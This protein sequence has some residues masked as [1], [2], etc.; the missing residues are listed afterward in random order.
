M[1]RIPAGSFLMGSPSDEPGRHDDEGPQHKLHLQEFFLARTPITQ[2][3]WR[4]VA[5]WQPLEGESAWERE[6][7]QDPLGSEGD[8]R[9]R[10][11]DRPVANVSWHDA[12]EFCRRLSKRTGKS[13][14]L[15]SEAQW[16]Y[17]CRA[18]RSTPFYFGATISPELANYD[19]SSRYAE[20]PKGENRQQTTEVGHF[21]ANVWGLHDMHG[22]VWE[23]CLDHWHSSYV[24][25]EEQ[26]PTDGSAWIK[27]SAKEDETR[28]LRGGSWSSLPWG[29]RSAYRVFLNPGDA[30][31]SVGFRV[32]CLPQDLLLDP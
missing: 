32:C 31:N 10:G 26:A 18:G 17:A 29:C 22:N 5:G 19:A 6:L 27:Q 12:M 11:D 28:L 13:Y 15:P 24:E 14:T 25:G 7:K 23:W 1:L 30:D 21:P 2:A 16:E 4:V 8:S 20:G 3:Q 9:F